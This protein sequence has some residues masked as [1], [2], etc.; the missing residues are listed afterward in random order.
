VRL[1]LATSLC[2]RIAHSGVGEGY[3]QNLS[4]DA[5]RSL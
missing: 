1:S 3:V 5:Q 4:T 2:L